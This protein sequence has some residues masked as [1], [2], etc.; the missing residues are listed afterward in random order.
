MITSPCEATSGH[1]AFQIYYLVPFFIHNLEVIKIIKNPLN[2][3]TTEKNK[4]CEKELEKG[5]IFVSNY[6]K[7]CELKIVSFVTAGISL[8][9]VLCI[10]RGWIWTLLF[11]VPCNQ[12]HSHRIRNRVK[13][14]A[15]LLLEGA[16]APGCGLA[17]REGTSSNLGQCVSFALQLPG[18]M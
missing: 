14:V 8:V 6:S 5:N 16:P 2:I 15:D 11:P 10:P 18:I 9:S 1:G 3:W 7:N 12:R 13:T 4:I 17:Y